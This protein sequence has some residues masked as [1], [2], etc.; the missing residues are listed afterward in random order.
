MAKMSEENMP[1]NTEDITRF[2][3]VQE[4]A[5]QFQSVADDA[6]SLLRTNFLI[7]GFFLPII[8]SLF[9]GQLSPEKVF[10]NAYTQV[11][12]VVWVLSTLLLSSIYHRARVV[13]KA[14]FD[15][16]EAEILGDIPEDK[17]R[18][19]IHDTI[20]KYSSS[21]DNLNLFIS[22][23]T[24]LT[25][26]VTTLFALGMLLPYLAIIPQF[27]ALIVVGAVLSVAA[28]ITISYRLRG[29]LSSISRL[30]AH[31]KS[32][33]NDLTKPRQDLLKKIYVAVG[34]DPFEL[35]DLPLKHNRSTR[36]GTLSSTTIDESHLLLQDV[37]DNKISE[38]LL[39]QMVEEGY[40]EKTGDT[41]APTIR[42]PHTYKEFKIN[43]IK[44]EL[45]TAIDRLGREL[46][47][48]VEARSTAADELSS[49][50]N[51]VLNEL[52]TGDELEQIKRYNRVI[53]RLQNEG[54]ELASRPFEFTSEEVTYIPTELAE[55]AYEK[56][57]M[58]QRT[59]EYDRKRAEKREQ[60][61][62]AENTYESEVIEPPNEYGEMQVLIYD[63]FSQSHEHK[64]LNIDE[65]DVSEA[66][67][68]RLRELESGEKIKLR[69]EHH[70]RDSGEYIASI[71][72][73]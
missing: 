30:F 59:R 45:G 54:F 65:A 52:R 6:R 57:E 39:E 64:Y 73:P 38:Y 68:E 55:Q 25:L 42:P 14:H 27:D 43:E 47:S 10:N 61:R 12:L 35:S 4:R 41:N 34:T 17:R 60:A 5:D 33:W 36:S 7:I 32:N 11:G 72:G 49:R 66:E 53:N 50:P 22:G 44:D 13:A 67:R 28:L 69:I 15:P 3:F 19:R 37:F 9:S 2:D 56:I 46:D 24:L 29:Y 58:E 16:V 40:F 31:N 48:N 1:S 26:I 18:Y 21:I 23:S 51:E 8:G 20:E 63:M 62:R 70:P 71:G